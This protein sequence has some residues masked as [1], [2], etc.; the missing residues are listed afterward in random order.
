MEKRKYFAYLMIIAGLTLEFFAFKLC[1]KTLCYFLKKCNGELSVECLA[2]FF[3]ASLLLVI[4]GLYILK[5]S[6]EKKYV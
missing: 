3:I 1:T 4:G 6:K 5:K 2:A